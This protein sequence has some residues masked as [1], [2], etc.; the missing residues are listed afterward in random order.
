M[1]L[2]PQ[3]LR[4]T[5][6]SVEIDGP[7]GSVLVSLEAGE[8][9]ARYAGSELV[10]GSAQAYTNSLLKEALDVTKTFPLPWTYDSQGRQRI[11]DHK[12]FYEQTFAPYIPGL[13]RLLKWI[14]F[15]GSKRITHNG[16]SPDLI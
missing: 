15:C 13:E 7:N 8:L 5:A 14:H 16:K 2:L 11:T 1:R 10:N 6:D 4:A 3:S 9:K 12:L